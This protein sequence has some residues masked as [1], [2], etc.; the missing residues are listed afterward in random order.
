MEE[1]AVKVSASCEELV[2]LLR[3]TLLNRRSEVVGG[4]SIW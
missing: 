2:K 4:H 3:F 1:A